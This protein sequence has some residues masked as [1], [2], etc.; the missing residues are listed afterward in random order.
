V[1]RVRGPARVAFGLGARNGEEALLA[2]RCYRV[3]GDWRSVG[4]VVLAVGLVLFLLVI[5][6]GWLVNH[7]AERGQ[8]ATVDRVQ[9]INSARLIL[10][11]AV[12][13][14]VLLFGAVQA[15]RQLQVSREGQLTERYTRAVEQLGSDNRGV[16]VG[17]IYALE[18][19]A[20]D[21]VR[22]RATVAEVLTTFVRERAV[23]QQRYPQHASV[24][25]PHSDPVA[26]AALVPLADLP[27]LR[28][29]A[30][31]VQA[32]ITVLGRRDLPPG[33][34]PPLELRDVDLRK[35]N[36]AG[37]DLR[38]ANFRGARLER[39]YLQD[40]RLEGA[41]LSRARLQGANLHGTHL[42]GADLREA[43][44]RGAHFLSQ[45]YLTGAKTWNTTWP[46]GFDPDAAGVVV[47]PP[48]SKG[49]LADRG[50]ADR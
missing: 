5:V 38:G 21:S 20:H 40:A 39:M 33:G 25:D 49:G 18:R 48:T 43:N 13:G 32:A 45:A 19:I 9:A 15:W 17:G 2:R 4:L 34:G 37:A 36:I 31:D 12:G 7:D 50:R 10:L 8:L 42:E 11:Q 35:G 16:R 14:V 26:E 47:V 27:Y 46:G 22:D 3:R 6:P 41:N 23:W 44:L 1:G 29:R 30:P 28:F 24:D